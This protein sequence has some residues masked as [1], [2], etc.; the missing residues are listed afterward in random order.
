[1]INFISFFYKGNDLHEVSHVPNSPKNSLRCL[2][3]PTPSL[4]WFL[5]SCFLCLTHLQHISFFLLI[6]IIELMAKAK[7]KRAAQPT[8]QK[9]T[10]VKTPQSYCYIMWHYQNSHTK[11]VLVQSCLIVTLCKIATRADPRLLKWNNFW[12]TH[13]NRLKSYFQFNSP[14]TS[15]SLRY[16]QL[17]EKSSTA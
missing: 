2:L 5:P 8:K 14:S 13:K 1:M 7:S 11:P 12:L 10:P 6:E 4:L 17:K 15:L 3:L 16:F 9:D